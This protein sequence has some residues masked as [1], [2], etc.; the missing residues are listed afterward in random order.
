[1]KISEQKTN[2]IYRNYY[3]YML[4]I[5]NLQNFYNL[6]LYCIAQ[7]TVNQINREQHEAGREENKERYW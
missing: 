6:I 3:K 5:Y 7:I 4:H 2:F 1:M